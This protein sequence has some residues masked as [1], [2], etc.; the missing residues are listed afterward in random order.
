VVEGAAMGTVGADY[1]MESSVYW[2]LEALLLMLCMLSEEKP[3]VV[4]RIR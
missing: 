3:I 4:D 2:A 1:Q